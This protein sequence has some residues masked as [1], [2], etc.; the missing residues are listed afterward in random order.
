MSYS[1]HKVTPIH[2]TMWKNYKFFVNLQNGHKKVK[3][4]RTSLVHNFIILANC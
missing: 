2:G 3:V 4:K 1:V